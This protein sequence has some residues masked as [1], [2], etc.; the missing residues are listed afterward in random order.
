MRL[1]TLL[2]L[3]PM[4]VASGC[5]STTTASSVEYDP[6]ETPN[7]ALFRFNE[8]V[9]RAT[10]KP[11]AKA[12]VKVVPEPARKGVTNFSRNLATPG[13]ALNNFLQGKPGLGF[14]EFARFFVNTTIG[15]GGLFDIAAHSGVEPN[16]ED[17]GQTAAVWGIPPGPFVMV[18]FLGPRTLRD[19]ATLPLNIMVDPLHY[20]DDSTIRL[21]L[22]FLRLVDV[23]SRLLPLEELMKDSSDPYVTMRESYLQ[24]RDFQIYDGDPPT[25]DDDEFYDEFLEEEDY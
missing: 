5:A 9:D 4:L 14:Q 22:W 19:T 24:N 7:R 16:M 15:I 25:T 12:Y 11:V 20:H 18:P 6:W 21:S 3:V 1:A 13:S 2:V 8:A 17:F 23:R 10:F